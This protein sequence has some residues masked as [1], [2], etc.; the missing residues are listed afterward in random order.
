MRHR[1]TCPEGREGPAETPSGRI[2]EMAGTNQNPI[3]E[4]N[5]FTDDRDRET[6]GPV[7]QFTPTIGGFV[8]TCSTGLSFLARMANRR[9]PEPS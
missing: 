8:D 5:V 1:L 2:D 7:V 6:G 4:N 9:R 3:R